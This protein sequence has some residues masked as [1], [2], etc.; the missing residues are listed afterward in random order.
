FQL[1]NPVQGNVAGVVA[2]AVYGGKLRRILAYLDPEKL[3]ARSLAPT[4]VVRALKQSSVFI[5]V[6]SARLGRTEYQLDTNALPPTVEEMNAF[7]LKESGGA[8]GYVRDV[9]D[10][11][12]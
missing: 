3:E 12:D 1:R 8:L 9:G 4:D 7:P 5:P 11:L 2:P 10:V 6:G